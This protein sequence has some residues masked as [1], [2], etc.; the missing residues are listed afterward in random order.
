MSKKNIKISVICTILSLFAISCISVDAMKKENN[1][2]NNINNNLNLKFQED[3]ESENENKEDEKEDNNNLNLN[4]D[5]EKDNKTFP[6]NMNFSDPHI[7]GK[8]YLSYRTAKMRDK[9]MEGYP[10]SEENSIKDDSNESEDKYKNDNKKSPKSYNNSSYKKHYKFDEI[11]NFD[12]NKNK[13][14]VYKNDILEK[15]NKT[16]PRNMAFSDPHIIGKNYQSYRTAKMRD[17]LMEVYPES[18][19]ISIK[20]DKDESE[21]KYKNDN[22]KSPKSYNNSSYKKYYKFDKIKNFDINKNKIDVYKNDD[23][24]KDN[25]TFPKNMIFLEPNIIGENNSNYRI[26]KRNGEL[27]KVYPES[28]ENSIKL[29]SHFKNN[30]IQNYINKI[31]ER[32]K[33]IQNYMLENKELLN[34]NYNLKIENQK[35]KDILKKNSAKEANKQS[36]D[37][38]QN[39]YNLA[40]YN[41]AVCIST[42]EG[43]YENNK[44]IFKDLEDKGQGIM[45]EMADIIDQPENKIITKKSKEDFK[46]LKKSYESIKTSKDKVMNNL[47]NMIEDINNH[48]ENLKFTYSKNTYIQLNYTQL[49]DMLIELKENI[50]AYI[51]NKT[52]NINLS[53]EFFK[54]I[55]ESYKKLKK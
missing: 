20:Y 3:S 28:E 17:K 55:N 4:D 51:K 47:K 11:K 54:N 32:D 15:D 19:E 6:K 8:N 14:D 35:L 43:Q 25:K 23:L 38:L 45:N 44:R 46:N 13:I 31:I 29:E 48:I 2:N 1:L 49:N 16:F 27:V 7:I 18:E 22:K 26:T 37:I 24:E 39:D 50:D 40:A 52:R 30:D 10:E 36:R 42:L 5:L 21:D 34:E 12:I 33:I 53:N 41:L 9:L